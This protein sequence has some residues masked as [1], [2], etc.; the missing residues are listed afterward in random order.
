MTNKIQI[1]RIHQRVVQPRPYVD[2]VS[3]DQIAYLTRGNANQPAPL[4]VFNT[5][6]NNKA[7]FKLRQVRRMIRLATYDRKHNRHAAAAVRFLNLLNPEKLSA[8]AQSR[9]A[10]M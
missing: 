7:G 9:R 8:L 10:P 4:I 5:L 3:L 1:N 2:L 6:A